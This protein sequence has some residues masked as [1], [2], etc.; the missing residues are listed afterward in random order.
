MDFIPDDMFNVPYGWAAL[1]HGPM[2]SGKTGELVRVLNRAEEY[3]RLRVQAFK[4]VI[5]DR[6]G[7]GVISTHKGVSFSATEVQNTQDII[8]RLN[9]STQVIGI[10]EIQFLDD[11]IVEFCKTQRLNHK[12]IIME[13][14]VLDYKQ[15]PFLF[16]NSNRSVLELLGQV[17]SV[18]RTAICGCGKQPAIY[19]MRTVASKEQVLVGG[20][21]SY[22]AA[23]PGCHKIPED[24]K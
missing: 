7:K 4:P 16:K 20:T 3:A 8:D 12:M 6:Y 11:K 14:L 24:T 10:S 22:V 9:P 2:F 13:G 23:C 1:I 15:A 21:D 19:T 5:D 17:Y 18:Q